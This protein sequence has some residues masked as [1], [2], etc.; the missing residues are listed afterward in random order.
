MAVTITTSAYVINNRFST[1]PCD[2]KIICGKYSTIGYGYFVMKSNTISDGCGGYYEVGSEVNENL[3]TGY[4]NG[5][6]YIKLLHVQSGSQNI[7][8]SQTAEELIEMCKCVPT[9]FTVVVDNGD[10]TYTAD[11]PD[12]TSV[13][14]TGATGTSFVG[15]VNDLASLPAANLH[16]GELW[17]VINTSAGSIGGTYYSNGASWI[18]PLTLFDTRITNL[19]NNVLKVTYYEIVSGAS[20]TITPPTGATFNSDE[21]GNSGNSIL[22]RINGANKPTYES[23]QTAGGV[24]VTANLNTTTGAWIA[25]GV[26]TDTNVAL[27]YSINIKEKDYA[28]LNPFYIIDETKLITVTAV[29]ASS[30]LAS[31]GGTA[32]NITI[33]QSGTVTNGYLSSTDWNTFNNKQATLVSGTTIKT[34]NG[35]S[36]LGSGDITIASGIEIGVTPITSGAAGRILYEG[37]TNKAASLDAFRWDTTYNYLHIKQTGIVPSGIVVQNSVNPNSYT[38]LTHQS[39]DWGR[40]QSVE[41][42]GIFA[43]DHIYL[44]ANGLNTINF[45]DAMYLNKYGQLGIG[46]TSPTAALHIKA[47]TNSLAPLKINPGVLLSSTENGAIES[48]GTHLYWTDSGGTRKQLD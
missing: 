15:I 19:E 6:E 25:S 23:P 44:K 26:Y 9:N 10:G 20:G 14:W 38:Q 48:D 34:I 43:R 42:L 7:W 32:P 46:I 27:I 47:G 36:I 13:T 41:Q 35:T 18:T 1:N 24:V 31:S 21:F 4:T 30:P 17:Y 29:T 11:M 33:T 37:L 5:V 8:V 40:L 22:S 2:V 12:G 45:T 39:N 16:T 28:N 3:T